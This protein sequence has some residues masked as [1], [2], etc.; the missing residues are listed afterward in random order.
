MDILRAAQTRIRRMGPFQDRNVRPGLIQG[1]DVDPAFG[2][3][4]M[5]GHVHLGV[6]TRVPMHEHRNDEILSYLWRGEMVHE[7]SA[8]HRVTVSAAK[9]MM[10]NAGRSFWHEERTPDV[11]VEMLQIMIRPREAD[12]PPDVAFFDRPDGP[13]TGSWS[14]VAG[15]EGSEAPLT[16]R[17]AV[18]FYDVRLEAGQESEVPAVPGLWPWL[19]VM[20]GLVG[21]GAERLEKGDAAS[22]ISGSLPAV[23][24]LA[25]TVL[26]LFLVDLTAPASRAGTISGQ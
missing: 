5:V 20:D 6:G 7:D 19:Y 13:A 4:S 26:V 23:R 10:M 8:G 12:L 9:L 15:P 25:D 17:N 3:L 2:P 22:D 14:L 18:R 1:P 24:A 21:I 11:P 16:V